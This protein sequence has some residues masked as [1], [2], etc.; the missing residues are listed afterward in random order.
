[1]KEF[2]QQLKKIMQIR[3]VGQSELCER[4]GIPKSAM[5]QYLSGAFKPKQQRT[6]LLAQAL[7]TTPE[8]LMGTTDQFEPEI[9]IHNVNAV[10]FTVADPPVSMKRIPVIGEVAAGYSRLADM[11]IL[12]YVACDTALL[13][14]GYDHVYLKVRGDSMEPL[15][16]EDDL[17]LVRVQDTIEDGE[18]AVVLVDGDSGL[19]K[20]IEIDKTHLTLISINPYYPPRTFEREEMNRV[21]IFG[22]VISSLRQF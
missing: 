16:L 12:D 20:K 13:H 3:G 2:S 14:S 18:Y 9:D 17:V 21:R 10:N 7:R 11:E 22:K 5:S 8:F 1:M 19:V 15:F 4:T 6:Y